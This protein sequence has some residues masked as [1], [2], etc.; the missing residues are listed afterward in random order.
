MANAVNIYRDKYGLFKFSVDVP[1]DW[2]RDEN[3]KQI[4]DE[5]GRSEKVA[6]DYVGVEDLNIEIDKVNATPMFGG[7][8]YD[9]LRN[10]N[11]KT[12]TDNTGKEAPE[13]VRKA[14]ERYEAKYGVV[15]GDKALLRD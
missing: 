14:V 12:V 9:I 2:P 8:A 1:T 4:V 13:H 5:K 15:Y 10:P 11:T 6:R 3:G 7:V